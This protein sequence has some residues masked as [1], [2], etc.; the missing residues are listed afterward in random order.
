[1]KQNTINMTPHDFTL[2]DNEGNV[3]RVI[4]PSGKTIRLSEETMSAGMW[5]GM[6]L[7]HTDYGSADLPE[8]RPDTKY[9]VSAMVKNSFPE[10]DDLIVPAQTV[11]N[12]K[13]QI[14][15][16]RSLGTCSKPTPSFPFGDWLGFF[17][18]KKR[19]PSG[20]L[21]TL[22]LYLL[23]YFYTHST[24]NQQNRL[25]QTLVRH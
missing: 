11:R 16:A 20:N 19:L 12:E 21:F 1:M 22:N 5:D 10:R 24:I 8:Y 9:I 25:H 14:V 23:T 15:G 17:L 7:T 13:N 3:V 18:L 6:P 2:Y 4:P